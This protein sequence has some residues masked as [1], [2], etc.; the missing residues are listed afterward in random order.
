MPRFDFKCPL[1]GN[2]RH[3]VW[4]SLLNLERKDFGKDISPC[5]RMIGD[6]L[7]CG[8]ILEKQPCAPNFSVK[9]FNAKNGYS[10]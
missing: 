5:L 8:G 10:K 3:D 4:V 9:G 1:C 7:V 2:V 6:G